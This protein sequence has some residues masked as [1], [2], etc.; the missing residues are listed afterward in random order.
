M[1]T[2]NYIALFEEGQNGGFSVVFPDMS[3]IVTSGRNFDETVRMA[4]GHQTSIYIKS[5]P[6]SL[7]SSM[8]PERI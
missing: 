5:A 1:K 8:T 3:G 2:K 6:V 4:H 7:S